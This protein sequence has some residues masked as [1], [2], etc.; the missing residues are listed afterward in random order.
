MVRVTPSFDEWME[1][2]KKSEDR[3]VPIEKASIKDIQFGFDNGMDEL[4][5]RLPLIE[6]LIPERVK[7][8]ENALS[9][10]DFLCK[11]Q[12]KEDVELPVIP[13]AHY[14]HYLYDYGDGWEVK[15]TLT[16]LYYTKTRWDVVKECDVRSR[17]FVAKV[18]KKL[19]FLDRTKKI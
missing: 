10:L 15:V 3:M 4:L 8:D 16:D 9:Q 6:L 2:G 19:I 14:I 13:M 17:T 5:E 11:R 1:K 12:E 7:R 18:D